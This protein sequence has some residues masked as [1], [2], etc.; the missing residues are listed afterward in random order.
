M[1]STATEVF[2]GDDSQEAL[3]RLGLSREIIN[4]V[5]MKAL[6][7]ALS[8][9]DN[10]PITM[11]GMMLWGK[12][13]RFFAEETR[14]IR[15]KRINEDNQALILNED[16]SIAVTAASGDEDT[17]IANGS[18][19]TNSQKGKTTI[20]ACRDNRQFSFA[21]WLDPAP[22]VDS[23]KVPGRST[24]FLLMHRDKKANVLRAEL[25]LP[26]NMDKDGYVVRWEKRIIFAP[27]SFDSI[28]TISARGDSGPD[29]GNAQS[30]EVT[31]QITRLG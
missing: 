23:T 2:E 4:N 15:W 5:L 16:G 20:A 6:D 10:D 11:A 30:P 24:W 14:P 3:T 28:P 12:G 18:P 21:D 26:V 7:A 9:N 25:S 1:N 22:A 31:V 19:C 29:G 8:C 17:G 27:I 13:V